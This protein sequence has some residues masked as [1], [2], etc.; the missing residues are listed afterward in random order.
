M[1]RNENRAPGS[2]DDILRRTVIEPDTSNRPSRAQEQAAREGFR[3][4]DD[5]ERALEASAMQALQRSGADV[6]HVEVEV[7]RDLV[8][9]RGSVPEARM[10]SLI[11]DALA[12]V[13]GIHTIHNKVV[14]AA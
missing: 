2:Y 1:P 8:T 6:T 5:D 9:V 13:P 4:V 11:E 3:A 7:T 10:L 12:A 14:V